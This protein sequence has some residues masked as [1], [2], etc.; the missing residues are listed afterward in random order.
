MPQAVWKTA[1]QF[2]SKLNIVS[3]YD[4]VITLLSLYPT[5]VKVQPHRICRGMLRAAF[6]IITQN[7]RNSDISPYKMHPVKGILENGTTV[8]TNKKEKIRSDE[9]V[10]RVWGSY[11]QDLEQVFGNL[12]K[13]HGKCHAVYFGLLIRAIYFPGSCGTINYSRV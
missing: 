8:N 9:N 3:K 2:L 4:Q 6:F 10:D 11:Q 7:W 12:R 5:Y 1:W 13:T